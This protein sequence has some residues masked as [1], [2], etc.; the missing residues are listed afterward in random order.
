MATE[1]KATE[2][3][4]W[5]PTFW[6]V[7][8][9]GC[10]GMALFGYDTGVVSGSL[11]MVSSDFELDTFRK[12]FA[13]SATVLFAAVGSVAGA[14]LNDT[15]GRKLVVTCSAVLY[16]VGSVV[17]ALSSGYEGFIVGRVLLGIAIGFAS[18]T[19]PPYTAELSP[20]TQR[21]MVV[22]LNALN[23]VLGQLLAGIINALVV[24]RDGGW[25]IAMGFAALPATV[26]L[27]GAFF[28]PE[29]PRWLA[30]QGRLAEAEA[31]VRSVCGEGAQAEAEIAAIR[32]EAAEAAALGSGPRA[33][34][35]LRRL[36]TERE[37][38]RAALLGVGLMALNQLSGINTVMYYSATVLVGVGFSARVAVWIAAVSCLAQLLGVCLSVYTMDRHGRRR[39][40]LRSAVAVV[41][42]LLLLSSCFY[43]TNPDDVGDGL[44]LKQR[45]SVASYDVRLLR[46]AERRLLSR[47]EPPG[48]PSFLMVECVS[49]CKALAASGVE[50]SHEA[51]R[52]ACEL[53][54]VAVSVERGAL[55]VGDVTSRPP[56]ETPTPLQA[57]AVV[58]LMLYLV[59]FGAG[60]SGVP[61]VVGSEI[62]PTDVRSTAVGQNTL[63]NWLFNF[64][65]AQT[66]LD[67]V[68]LLHSYGAFLVYACFSAIGGLWLYFYLPETMH[69]SLEQI[70]TLFH[71]PYPEP[72]RGQQQ[73]LARQ[74]V[75]PSPKSESDKLL[76]R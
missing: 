3:K 60:L 6:R 64:I 67:L 70:A 4:A 37:L 66:F 31:V 63:S 51:C 16:I 27:F 61:W 21:G 72:L 14:P 11:I 74:A 42:S 26:M 69:L 25:R 55:S 8:I 48:G 38:R 56:D 2:D 39:T 28:L 73:R 75:A 23:I 65:V 62:Y 43:L 76:P 30:L 29:S 22:T 68:Q 7:M 19:V 35:R 18:G 58:S 1:D 24:D 10:V 50:G 59:A 33:W 15:Y 32:A 12:E 41:V 46:T 5:T 9:F 13:V 53:R 52:L 36:W 54:G 45:L 17:I 44:T 20:P 47:A 34:A 57:A 40:A 49:S 71:D